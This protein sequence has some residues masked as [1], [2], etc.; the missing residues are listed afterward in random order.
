[1]PDNMGI[2]AKVKVVKNKVAAPFKVVEL[3]ILFGQGVDKF[4]CL[5][6]A[7]LDLNV[8]ERKGSWYSYEDSN[9]A[10]GRVN[11]SIFLKNNRDIAKRMENEVR[12]AM[13]MG[14]VVDSDVEN[15]EDVRFSSEVM[16]DEMS[17]FE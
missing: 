14:G 7:A 5:L 4:G 10:Q 12:E 3:D 15:E 2:R 11:A 8:V 9:F 1:M 6:D 13:R 17:A 16:V